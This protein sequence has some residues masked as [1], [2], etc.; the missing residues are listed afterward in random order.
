MKRVHGLRV[1][2]LLLRSAFLQVWPVLAVRCMCELRKRL[3][4]IFRQRAMNARMEIP[5]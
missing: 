3:H 2:P 5:T 1:M 4:A